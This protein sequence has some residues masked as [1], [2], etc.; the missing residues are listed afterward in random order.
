MEYYYRHLLLVDD[1][2]LIIVDEAGANHPHRN[3][4][5]YNLQTHFPAEETDYGFLIHGKDNDLH[6]ILPEGDHNKN[7]EEWAHGRGMKGPKDIN[8][9]LW[10]EEYYRTQSVMVTILSTETDWTS[11]VTDKAVSVKKGDKEF[12]VVLKKPGWNPDMP[13]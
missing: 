9:M 1:E 12:M 13:V 4:A 11:F 6:V 8:K 7:I 10:F 5:Q 3:D 2:T